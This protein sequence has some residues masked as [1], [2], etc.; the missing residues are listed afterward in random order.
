MVPIFGLS[1][2]IQ[3]HKSFADITAGLYTMTHRQAS[4]CPLAKLKRAFSS[5]QQAF[6]RVAKSVIKDGYLL[7]CAVP[8]QEF[9]TLNVH[10]VPL[11]KS[12]LK[13]LYVDFLVLDS[14]LN[15]VLAIDISSQSTP[16]AKSLNSSRI[17]KSLLIATGLP[18][19]MIPPALEYDAAVI[20]SYFP[21]H[22][23]RS[24]RSSKTNTKKY[25]ARFPYHGKYNPRR[26]QQPSA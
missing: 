24:S 7:H 2:F 15:P 22:I 16:S 8:V 18:F 21:A 26:P 14:E 3:I 23:L 19:V 25:W 11:T 13:A 5:H 20:S 4:K 9:L 1:K 17:K 12:Q 6:L 10:A